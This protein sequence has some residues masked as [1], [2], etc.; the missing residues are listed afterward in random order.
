M[1]Y[2]WI[3]AGLAG[4]ATGAGVALLLKRVISATGERGERGVDGDFRART[5]VLRLSGVTGGVGG[6]RAGWEKLLQ[7]TIDMVYSCV[8]LFSR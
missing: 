7:M 2:E 1:A 3:M 5:G 6:R 8:S 4:G